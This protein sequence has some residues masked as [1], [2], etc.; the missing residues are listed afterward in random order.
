VHETGSIKTYL[1]E[2]GYDK[3]KLSM[4]GLNHIFIVLPAGE[5]YF[6]FNMESIVL[7]AFPPVLIFKMYSKIPDHNSINLPKS[8]RNL[9]I[10]CTAP[11][12]GSIT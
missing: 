2:G 9:A 5:R 8:L 4:N 7:T 6:Y 1:A 10:R 3:Y 12:I 11:S